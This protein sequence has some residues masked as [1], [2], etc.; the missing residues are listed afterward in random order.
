VVREEETVVVRV[1]ETVV[2]RVEET[3][4]EK[5]EETGVEKRGGGYCTVGEGEGVCVCARTRKTVE[6]QRIANQHY[7]YEGTDP[8]DV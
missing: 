3:V 8:Q 4:A 2:V 6:R 1:E 7:P 5:G